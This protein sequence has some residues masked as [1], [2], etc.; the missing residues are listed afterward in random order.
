MRRNLIVA[1]LLLLVPLAWA[2][3]VDSN[4]GYLGVSLQFT[5]SIHKDGIPVQDG[6]GVFLSHV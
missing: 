1:A 3:K 4:R 5:E 6:V 2:D